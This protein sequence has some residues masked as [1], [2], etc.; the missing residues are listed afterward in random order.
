MR[1]MKTMHMHATH[2]SSHKCLEGRV[3]VTAGPPTTECPSGSKYSGRPNPHMLVGALVNGP[4]KPDDHFSDIRILDNSKVGIHYN[5]GFTGAAVK[6]PACF[7]MSERQ[8]QS[9]LCQP[10]RTACMCSQLIVCSAS[11]IQLWRESKLTD[12]A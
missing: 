1:G 3:N 10:L 12:K 7:C 5:A 8:A 6:P 9:R 4:Q 2:S 11:C